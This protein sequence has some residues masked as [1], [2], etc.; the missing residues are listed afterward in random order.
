MNTALSLNVP[1][2]AETTET[3]A[4]AL[5]NT[6]RD[7]AETINVTLETTEGTARNDVAK[8]LAAVLNAVARKIE[9]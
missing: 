4:V 1:P 2:A 8:A 6:A 5:L 9:G 3:D 7:L